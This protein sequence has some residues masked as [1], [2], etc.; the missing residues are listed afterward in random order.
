VVELTE[1]AYP[2]VKPLIDEQFTQDWVGL[3][4]G[5]RFALSDPP[6]RAHAATR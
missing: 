1:E 5:G 6:S 3:D 2:W 4:S